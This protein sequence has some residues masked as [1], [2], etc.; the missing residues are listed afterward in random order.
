MAAYLIA[1]IT[2]INPDQ[3]QIYVGSVGETLAPFGAEVMFRGKR[4][5]VL[6]G[7]HKFETVA[8]LK[9]PD[10]AAINNWYDSDAYQALA[11]TRNRAANAVFISYNE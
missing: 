6:V 2:V 10:E 5:A 8:V 9:F 11:Q 1:H 7:E 4:A 3:W